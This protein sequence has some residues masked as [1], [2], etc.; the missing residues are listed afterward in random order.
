LNGR[1]FPENKLLD[2]LF[3]AFVR[4]SGDGLWWSFEQQHVILAS[5][6]NHL[7]SPLDA[8]SLLHAVGCDDGLVS[9]LLALLLRI[10]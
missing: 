1:A 7:L 9:F 2:L 5:L 8:V 3:I 4:E 6:G 10:V